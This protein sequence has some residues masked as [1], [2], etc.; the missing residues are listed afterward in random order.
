[1]L[2]RMSPV[3]PLEVDG[4][5]MVRAVTGMA[6]NHQKIPYCQGTIWDIWVLCSLG[7]L[8][9]YNLF[10][11]PGD[12]GFLLGFPIGVYFVW[13]IPFGDFPILNARLL[14]MLVPSPASRHSAL[15]WDVQSLLVVT[16]PWPNIVTC[17]TSPALWVLLRNAFVHL[18]FQYQPQ[19]GYFW[20]QHAGTWIVHDSFTID[21]S[22]RHKCLGFGSLPI[23]F[24]WAGNLRKWSSCLV[25][26]CHY[27][28]DIYNDITNIFYSCC[29]YVHCLI[30]LYVLVYILL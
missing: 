9:D 17:P 4:K 23:T 7:I 27:P 22:L 16:C 30:N 1:M 15:L 28:N 12:I 6:W 8:R 18:S 10:K 26:L 21:P 13:Y 19:I 20:V 29:M 2:A 14:A 5:L 25:F 24:F 11:Y 3:L